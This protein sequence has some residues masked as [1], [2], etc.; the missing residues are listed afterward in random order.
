MKLGLIKA[1]GKNKG[2][3]LIRQFYMKLMKIKGLRPLR[4]PN[5]HGMFLKKKLKN[6]QRILDIPDFNSMCK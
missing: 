4:T 2:V 6:S 1:K 5:S 3:L